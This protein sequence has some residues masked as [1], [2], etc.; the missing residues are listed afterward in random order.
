MVF[1]AKREKRLCEA[2]PFPPFLSFIHILP[3]CFD[4]AQVLYIYPPTDIFVLNTSQKAI[5]YI[6]LYNNPTSIK[7]LFLTFAKIDHYNNRGRLL[8]LQ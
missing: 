6:L 2:S 8:N 4:S 7:R 3:I 1:G 5:Q